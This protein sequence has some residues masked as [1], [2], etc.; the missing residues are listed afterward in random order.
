MYISHYLDRIG[1]TG[2]LQPS[3][4]T[5]KALQ[6]AHL[7]AIPYENL[8]IH[9]GRRLTLDTQ[10]I[11]Q[12]IVIEG[13]GGWCYEMNGLFAWALRELGF[14]VTLLASA[15]NRAAHGDRA[16]RNHLILRV[17]LE[18]PYLA[19]VGFGNGFRFPLPLAAGR[20]PHDFQEFELVADDNHWRL[21]D[22]GTGG[23]G[24]DFT[25][26]PRQMSDFAAQ[27][28]TLQTS[29]ESGFVK[30]TV[31]YRFKPEGFINLRGAVLRRFRSTGMVEQTIA[32]AGLYR[33]VL[34][35]Q[36]GLRLSVVE[37]S[38]LWEAVRQRHESY[39]EPQRTPRPD[40]A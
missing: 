32:D 39:P 5:L 30:N 7:L 31:C 6:Q 2:D 19:D 20:Y 28:Q 22:L 21:L 3:A 14:Q 23:P 11:Y 13:R 18:R 36:F 17:D 26:E 16:E 33:T 4:A 34:H 8:D 40:T 25:L 10:A 24:Y 1:Y 15:V 12:K 37:I 27:C 38:Q 9:L 35:D 29:P